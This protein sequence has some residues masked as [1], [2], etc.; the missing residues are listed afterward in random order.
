[1][2][3][4]VK[5]TVTAA[6]NEQGHNG[7]GLYHANQVAAFDFSERQ[8]AFATRIMNCISRA[9]H[10]IGASSQ[11]QEL[12]FWNLYM[13]RNLG[14][15][16]IMNKPEEFIEGVKDIYGE[17]GIV[18]FE[19]MMTKEIKKEF[20]LTAEFDREPIQARTASDL[21]SLIAYAASE[22]DDNPRSP[23]P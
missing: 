18:V 23:G 16:D 21:L 7:G 17:A 3:V 15:D 8:A 9:F 11:T 6:V 4:R 13:T 20:G 2:Y 5:E 19:H 22:S 12:V 1:M 14:R 10:A